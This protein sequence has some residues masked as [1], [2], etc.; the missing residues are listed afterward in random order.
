LAINCIHDPDQL[1]GYL[2]DASNIKG[3]ASG[4]VRPSDANALSEVVRH[5]QHENIPLTVS[6][7]RTS[8][9]GGPVPNGGWILSMEKQDKVL[10]VD[11]FR[12][13]VQGGVIL[14]QFQG[15]LAN[16]GLVFP[17]DPTSRHECTIGAAIACNASGAK[18]FRYGPTRPWI[19]ALQVVLPDG[20]IHE[21]TRQ[22]PIPEDWPRIDW[23]PPKI[24][25]A[26]GYFPADNLLDLFIGQ[27]GTLGVIT[28]ATLRLIPAPEST[29][30][31]L[32][33]FS[34]L[35]SC[36]ALVQSLKDAANQ[37]GFV[38]PS[39]IEFYGPNAID[40]IRAEAGGLSDSAQY[41]IW[42]EQEGDSKDEDAS[43]EAWLT[44]LEEAGA[45]LEETLF[46]QDESGRKRLAQ[47]RHAVPA[48]INE[49][50]VA[51]GMPKVGT[52]CAVPWTALPEM[53]ETY[54]AVPLPHVLFG[55][56]GDSH[57]HLNILPKN[58]SELNQAKEIYRALCQKAVA[59]GGS[60][61]AEHGIGKIKQAHL[62]AMVG[63][64]VIRQ[65]EALKN[66]LDPNWI[67]CRGN[68]FAPP[69][70]KP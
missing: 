55:H 58:P 27:E 65:F 13:R 42:S 56:I 49:Q 40:F 44:L 32:S 7:Q 46:A 15:E 28:E 22:D 69:N 38:S 53:M 23:Q 6:A 29:F 11:G 41:G 66:H 35:E 59:L 64:E 1:E 25:T 63:A 24:K 52:D 4:L 16:Q 3:S 45:N 33:F 47:M 9:T 10:W 19:E 36:L 5:C 17:P 2:T 18:S 20:S 43:I 57:L 70:T 39:S 21:I 8:T 60:V 34:S 62:A 37:K 54:A 68:L 48:G 61:S 30:S 26:A 14:G 67:L 51:N 50:V 31:I 12:A